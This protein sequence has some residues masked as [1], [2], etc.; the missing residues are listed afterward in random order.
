MKNYKLAIVIITF[1]VS[2]IIIYILHIKHAYYSN[3]L[4]FLYFI[5]IILSSSSFGVSGG[6]VCSFAMFSLYIPIIMMNFVSDKILQMQEMI[7][8][9]FLTAFTGTATG[10]ILLKNKK[11]AIKFSI[12]SS[13]YQEELLSYNK[14]GNFISMTLNK[15]KKYFPVEIKNDT[16]F[17]EK[18]YS[19]DIE[20]LSSV[21]EIMNSFV[22][23][24]T[25]HQRTQNIKN[26][27]QIVLDEINYGIM[28]LDTNGR[29]IFA[30]KHLKKI[31]GDE[32]INKYYADCLN[33]SFSA[34]IKEIIFILQN[35]NYYEDKYSLG[36]F[37]FIID[38][39]KIYSNENKP[40]GIIFTFEDI[41]NKEKIIAE[42]EL[43]ALISNFAKSISYEAKMSF[44]VIFGFISTLLSKN[45]K[46]FS[47][48][49]R[50]FYNIIN[51][52]AE[53]LIRLVNNVLYFSKIQAGKKII[54][55]QENI[56]VSLM[57]F[58]EVS[59][60]KNWVTSCNFKLNVQ[61]NI[62]ISGDK[63]KLQLII[64]NLLSHVIKHSYPKKDISVF[65]ESKN[66]S[67]LFSLEYEGYFV[68][69]EEKEKIFLPF[70]TLKE[71]KNIVGKG[72]ELFVAKYLTL[73]HQGEIYF[74][75]EE[76]KKTKFY[77][78][79]PKA[80]FFTTN[81]DVCIEDFNLKSEIFNLKAST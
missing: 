33:N 36:D 5:P 34:K 59:F 44:S 40:T 7:L 55:H 47:E 69:E 41:K 6:V 9:I 79:L 51:L 54:L 18:T 37:S 32:I 25:L 64:Y 80:T 72:I 66:N 39:L 35:R 48:E 42:K 73:L 1:L 76:K 57:V 21:V 16:I 74:E 23:K 38:A 2:T 8:S 30:N 20:Y 22:K 53:R 49:K 43:N 11:E 4:Q 45:E 71:N 70:S 75:S 15:I 81:K 31:M 78:K 27:I 60:I 67:M 10:A 58:E 28:V 61:D 68:P 50:E 77:I 62:I 52:E 56:N 24:H 17:I 46:Q 63:E 29:I 3:I 14:S 12:L 26:F 13:I 19:E 65:L